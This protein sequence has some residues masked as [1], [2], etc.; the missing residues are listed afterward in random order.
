MLYLILHFFL[1]FVWTLSCSVSY[2]CDLCILFFFL[3]LFQHSPALFPL[4]CQTVSKFLFLSYLFQFF[5]HFPPWEP[6]HLPCTA[7]SP[8]LLHTA[9]PPLLSSYTIISSSC[10]CSVAHCST[11][12]LEHCVRKRQNTFCLL[13]SLPGCFQFVG[14]AC[15]W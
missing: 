14:Q 7:P 2:S 6:S 3:T 1:H 13:K 8:P 4:S 5:S 11:E 15:V 9:S 10:T 12:E